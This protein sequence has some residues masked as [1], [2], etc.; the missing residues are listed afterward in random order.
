MKMY[1]S[2]VNRIEESKNYNSDKLIH[3]GDSITMY[4]W[5]DRTCYYVVDVEN[6]KRIKVRKYYIC[7]DHSKP[8]GMGHQDWMYFKTADEMH[9]YLDGYFPGTYTEHVEEPEPE[10]WVYRYNNWKQEV[11]YTEDNYCDEKELK[12]LREKGYYKR[13]FDLSGKISFGVRSYYYDYEF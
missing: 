12:S 11:T 3:V 6:Q 2:V 13:Y 8:G 9:R 5:S 1:G 10:T 7:A 4:Y